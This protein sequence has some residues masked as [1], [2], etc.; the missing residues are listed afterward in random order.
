MLVSII[1]NT[2][3]LVLNHL[4]AGVNA[5]PADQLCNMASQWDQRECN[6][7]AADRGWWDI[8]LYYPNS[9]YHYHKSGIC[10]IFTMCQNGW[11]EDEPPKMIIS[12]IPVTDNPYVTT[13]GLQIGS[14]WLGAQ[15]RQH[16]VSFEVRENM[17]DASVASLLEG[18]LILT[19]QF[20]LTDCRKL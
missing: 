6:I 19:F 12:C 17:A 2:I 8:C 7:E 13:P 3:F 10:P 15:T 14:V 20:L 4:Y 16:N 1:V 11:M 18:M 9:Q 5:V